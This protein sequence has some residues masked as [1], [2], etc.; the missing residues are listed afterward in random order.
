MLCLASR[1]LKSLLLLSPKITDSLGRLDPQGAW[2][3]RGL[4]PP[5]SLDLRGAWTPGE[6]GPPGSLIIQGDWS[7]R[8]L[9]PPR[10]PGLMGAWTS[11]E[12]GALGRLEPQGD[13]R[14]R[15]LGPPGSLDPRETGDPGS[16]DFLGGWSLR[17]CVA[18]GPGPAGSQPGYQRRAASTLD[19]PGCFSDLWSSG[20]SWW[21]S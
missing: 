13:W 5:G 3:P 1:G 8:E 21:Y 4:G 18:Q 12:T 15:E 2:S 20:V 11:R 19:P 9:G 16:L 7:P 10:D 14:P 6:L 17:E